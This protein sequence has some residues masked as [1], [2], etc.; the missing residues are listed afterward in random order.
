MPPTSFTDLQKQ[1]TQRERELEALRQEL[2]SRQS[3]LSELTR[4]KEELQNQLQQVEKEIASLAAAAAAPGKKPTS[5]TSAAPRSSPS[6]ASTEGQP[7]MGEW[8]VILLREANKPMTARQ[9]WEEARKRGFQVASRDPIKALEHRLQ[10]LKHRGIVQRASG[11][12]GFILTASVN[13][14]KKETSKPQKPA[15]TSTSKT[16]SRPASSEPTDS[17]SSGKS[18]SATGAAKPAKSGYRGGQP[19]LR[20]VLTEL[21]KKSRKPLSGSELAK[22]ALA[23]GYKTT[24]E[25]FV[26]SVWAMLAQMDNIEHVPQEGYRLKKS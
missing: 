18:A 11:Q 2:E 20:V 6:P 13:G 21:L 16:P 26:D 22:R 8:V 7:R 5:A 25:K 14:D 1:I 19:P 4:R 9:L 17:S 12:P 24:S 23:A 10:D 3:H 15:Q